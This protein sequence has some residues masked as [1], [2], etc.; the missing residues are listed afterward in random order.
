MNAG[1]SRLMATRRNLIIVRGGDNSLHR[2]WGAD[3]PGCEFD[4]IVSYYGSDPLAFRRP[5]ENRVDYKGGKWDGIHALFSRLLELLDRY[6]YIW[7]PDDDLEADRTIAPRH[8]PG[9]GGRLPSGPKGVSA[10]LSAEETP[11][12]SSAPTMLQAD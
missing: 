3:D 6:Q 9:H 5:Y 11:L 8:R 2:R 7:I 12:A 10:D 1:S 4:L